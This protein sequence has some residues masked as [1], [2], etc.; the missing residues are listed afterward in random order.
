MSSEAITIAESIINKA[1]RDLVEQTGAARIQLFDRT[2]I[3]TK[4]FNIEIELTMP[5][6]A[7]KGRRWFCR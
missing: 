1:L 4:E 6:K 7:T 2:E 5:I 3:G